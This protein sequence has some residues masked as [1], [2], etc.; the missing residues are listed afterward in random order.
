MITKDPVDPAPYPAWDDV[1]SDDP[2]V[3]PARVSGEEICDTGGPLPSLARNSLSLSSR[4]CRLSLASNSSICLWISSSP[5]SSSWI[6]SE[7][8]CYWL[9]GISGDC[10]TWILEVLRVVIPGGAVLRSIALLVAATFLARDAGIAD[11]GGVFYKRIWAKD[12]DNLK[13]DN[14]IC[15]KSYAIKD[16]CKDDMQWPFLRNSGLLYI[17]LFSFS[18]PLPF[19]F[20]A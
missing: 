8:W 13:V 9:S 16:I 14:I 15:C 20:A 1:G 17:L 5:R 12:M 10:C 19:L 4:R 3:G 11:I 7:V 2:A 6:S 18:S